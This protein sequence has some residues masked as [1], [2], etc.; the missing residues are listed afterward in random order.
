M[1]IETFFDPRTWT[2]THL[3]YD[4]VTKDAAVIDPVL[5]YDPIRVKVYDDSVKKL[6]ARIAELG[7]KLHWVLETHAHADHMTGGDLLRRRLGARIAIGDRIK[8]VQEVFTG[9]FQ[10]S[11]VPTDGS[12]FDALV[13][14]GGEVKA[15]SLTFKAIATPGHTPACVSWHVGDAVFTGDA[16]FMPDQGT[17]RCD[18]PNGSA[19]QLYDSIQKLY[20][21]PPETRIFVGHDYQPGGRELR[22]E[23]TVAEE[24]DANIQ[25]R[26]DTDRSQFVEWRK[27]RDAT[28]NLPN[29]IF[30]SLQVNVRAG[31]LPESNDGKR[32]L[33]MPMN[34]FDPPVPE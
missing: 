14:D 5:D 34:L 26:G 1:N 16:I 7:L 2:L 9:I 8:N 11:D 10:L 17:G 32:Y 15:G 28:L 13:A 29:L 21:L 4:P 30:Q 31:A 25:L 20:A 19:E 23:T 12:Q 33:K 3:V 22:W 24:K 27:A 18:F 6:E